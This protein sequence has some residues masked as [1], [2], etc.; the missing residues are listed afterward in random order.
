MRGIWDSCHVVKWNYKLIKYVKLAFIEMLKALKG[1]GCDKES[2]C[3]YYVIAKKKEKKNRERRDTVLHG[4][5]SQLTELSAAQEKE[6]WAQYNL[7]S[8]KLCSSKIEV[9]E[10]DPKLKI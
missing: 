7:L 6:N 10:N 4:I 8:V 1:S 3:E 5:H 9:I 2:I